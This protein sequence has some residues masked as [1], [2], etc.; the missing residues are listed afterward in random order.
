MTRLRAAT[1]QTFRSLQIRNF[2]LFFVGQA[3]SQTGTWLQLVAQT[4]LVLE[5]TQSGVALGVVT[6]AQ[7]LPILVLGAW[8]GVVT[9]RVDKRRLLTVTQSAMMALALVMGGLVLSGH[10][11]VNWV[12]LLAL[13]TG[14]GT[15]FDNPARRVLVN[16]LVPER[17]VTNAVSLNSTLMTGSRMVGPAMAGVLVATVGIGWCFVV[18]GLSFVAVLV[19]LRRI[20]PAAMRVGARSAKGE[21]GQLRAG[22]RYVWATDELRVPLLMLGAVT[23]LAFNFQVLT[24]LF[25]V[26]TLHGGTGAYTALASTTSAG[27]VLGSLW[28]ARREALTMRLLATACVAF[29]AASVAFA[30]S[31]TLL[32]AALSGVLVGTT[33]IVVLSGTNAVLQLR[34]SPEMRG[35]VLALFTVVFL[36]STPIG[37]PIAGWMAEAFGVRV[38][39]GVGAVTALLSGAVVLARR[40]PAAEPVPAVGTA[41]S[42]GLAAA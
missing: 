41:P 21:K 1:R 38:A 11:T 4:L 17:A 3:V 24:P 23:V 13:L 8:G 7:F 2:R 27:A 20:D 22:L 15:A 39:L 42:E 35:R 26:R 30:L 18:N 32:L 34:A 37:G 40:R 33:S 10:A 6:A 29:G 9:D 25:A 28:L 5:L 14:V 16:E 12:Y 19:A 36:G 31:P